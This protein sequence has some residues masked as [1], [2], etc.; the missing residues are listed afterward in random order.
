MAEAGGNPWRPPGA[1]A[2]DNIQLALE[3]LQGWRLQNLSVQPVPVFDHPQG[4]KV[5]FLHV[6]MELHVSQFVPIA[7]RPVS[8]HY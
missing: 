4:K 1:A 3:H 5:G 6:Q 8:G 2:Q 7:S